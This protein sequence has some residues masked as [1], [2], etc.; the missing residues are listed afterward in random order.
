MKKEITS[1]ISKL[2]AKVRRADGKKVIYWKVTTPKPGGGRNRRFFPTESD[3][4]AYI[5]LQE[6][7]LANFG[8]AGASMNERLRGAA[9]RAQEILEPLGLDL[10]EA[11][12]HYAAHHKAVT[13]GIK[14]AV[15]VERFLLTRSGADYS[16]IYRKALSHHLKRFIE[17]FPDKTSRTITSDEIDTFLSG[18]GAVESVKT[19][20]R[21]LTSFFNYLVTEN[22]CVKNPVRKGKVSDVAY[23][24]EILTPHQCAKLLAACDDDT[25]PAVAI[26]LFCGLRASEIARLDWSRVNLA[27]QIIVI[28]SA[29]AR[30]TGARRVV[31]MPEACK[32]WLTPYAKTEGPV[33]PSDFRNKF[34]LVRV[35]AGYKPSFSERKDTALQ[36]VLTDAKKRKVKLHDWPSNCL[37]HSAISYGMAD[38]GDPGKVSGWAGNSPAMIRQHYDAQATPSAA[39]AFYAIRPE[40]AGNIIHSFK[41]KAA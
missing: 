14:L 32:Q 18:C 25:L 40:Q 1:K 37:R 7:Q 13:G 38:C 41:A 9:I 16:P 36:E 4:D 10:V 17:A 11:A 2:K 21:I 3:A 31:P 39:K 6:V 26:G 28:D 12:K 35:R 24:V 27:E 23:T 29:V 20:R 15:A 19:Y 8:T 22:H 33:Q 34:D 5:E 30:K